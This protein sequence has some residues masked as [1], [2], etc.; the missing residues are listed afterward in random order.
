ME[1]LLLIA[2]FALLIKGADW[3]VDGAAGAAARMRIPTVIVGLTIVSLGTSLP[4]LSVSLNAAIQ[5]SNALALSNV[6]G[7][8]LFNLS[9]I[10]I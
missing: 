6:V 10:H 5:G 3:F 8:N 7:S 9:L 4:E 2:G 1:Y